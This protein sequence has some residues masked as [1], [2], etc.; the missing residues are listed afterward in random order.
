MKK[1]AVLISGALF[2]VNIAMA[3]GILTAQAIFFNFRWHS[4][5]SSRTGPRAIIAQRY[6]GKGFEMLAARWPHHEP[7]HSQ[8]Q[9]EGQ[10]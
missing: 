8:E 4:H 6:I 2:L 3:G 1:F 5:H 9:D 10:N 7:D